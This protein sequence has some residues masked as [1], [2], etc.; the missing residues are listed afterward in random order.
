MAKLGV[1]ALGIKMEMIEA[2]LHIIEFGR[3]EDD[4]VLV[5]GSGMPFRFGKILH[6]AVTPDG[7]NLVLSKDHA[8][9]QRA[10]LEKPRGFFSRIFGW[11]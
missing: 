9:H 11:S 3:G 8:A 1:M 6:L 4:R 2:E 10:E 5:H 7:L